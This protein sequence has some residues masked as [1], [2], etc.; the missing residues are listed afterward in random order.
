MTQLL[1]RVLG[2]IPLGWLQLI[3]NRLRFAAAAAG[4]GFACVLV[5]VQLGMM[6]AFS[7]ATRLS[8]TGFVADIMISSSDAN[9]LTDGSNV[10][11]RRMYQA[12]GVPGVQEATPLFIG[13]TPWQQPDGSKV[14]FRTFGIDP[15][16][17]SFF[18]GPIGDV[19]PLKLAN[20]ALLDRD[21]RGLPPERLKGV[22]S[23]SP[24][25]FEGNGQQLA[26]VGTVTFGGGF[27][28]D[29]FMFVSDQTF[30][31]L[32][33]SRISGA[34]NHVL[35]KIDE[36]E[37]VQD[38]V[39]RIQDAL[40][41]DTIKVRALS[42]AMEDDVRYQ[43]T[44]RPTGLIFGF[45]VGIGVVVGIV[46]VY[47]ILSTDVADH[48]REYATFKAMG[49]GQD[50][51]RKI[52][53]EE[54]MILAIAGFVPALFLAIGIYLVMANATGLPIEMSVSRAGLVFVGT[55]ASCALSGIIALRKLANA[56]PA[57]L[58]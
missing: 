1:T 54:A 35:L 12:L 52:I 11:R 8:Y 25:V 16:Q 6:G 55:V 36:G 9:D 19:E 31:R 42:Q 27:S 18:G 22:T 38:V 33:P 23:D 46:I 14:E 13:M 32:F 57:D 34:P 20:N 39:K 40:N 51:F 10:A 58:F 28:G 24:I 17:S 37:N 50:Y 53:L 56:D 30:M 15:A 26:V 4:V 49:Y 48:L 29:G 47:Q 44:V 45:G 43:T 2:R 7:E 41:T 21:A 5:F 3:S